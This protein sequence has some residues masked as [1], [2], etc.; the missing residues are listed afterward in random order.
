M[1]SGAAW[2]VVDKK[3]ASVYPLLGNP[4]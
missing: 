4:Y 3:I 1:V 2:F